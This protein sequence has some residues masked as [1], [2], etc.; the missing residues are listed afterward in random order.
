MKRSRNSFATRP[1]LV[2]LPV[3]VNALIFSFLS[4]ADHERAA[5]SSP[6]LRSISRLIDA[7]PID[8][9]VSLPLRWCDHKHDIGFGRLLP[10]PI[11]LAFRQ[12]RHLTLVGHAIDERIDGVRRAQQPR[13]YLELSEDREPEGVASR[14]RSRTSLSP[15]IRQLSCRIGD[16]IHLRS[17][18]L[19]LDAVR[20]SSLKNR[21][22][23]AIGPRS[24]QLDDLLSIRQLTALRTLSIV[25][26]VAA[27][28]VYLLV[29]DHSHSILTP[30]VSMTGRWFHPLPLR[31][32]IPTCAN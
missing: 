31:C 2:L 24:I 9:S 19:V 4:F 30:V 28:E 17:L 20:P 10:L 18:S 1:T 16:L 29:V 3:D 25:G 32:S 27:L 23:V 6:V 22:G 13:P 8:A 12:L 26:V 11:G 15:V 5:R 14:L 7:A 21:L